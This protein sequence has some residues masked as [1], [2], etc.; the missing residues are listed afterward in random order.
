MRLE[1]PDTV[2]LRDGTT[3]TIRPIRPDDARGLQALFYRL[4]PESISLRFLGQPKELA[5]RFGQLP[6]AQLFQDPVDADAAFCVVG[7]C[8]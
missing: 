1:K 2:T 5:E 8:I 6:L 7:G 4:S 3:V